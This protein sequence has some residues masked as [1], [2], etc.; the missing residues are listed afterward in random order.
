[1]SGKEVILGCQCTFSVN[2]MSRDGSPVRGKEGTSATEESFRSDKERVESGDQLTKLLEEVRR[3][4]EGQE[5]AVLK[6]ERG[7][8]RDPYLLKRRGNENQFR[9]CEEL[10]D[11]VTTASSSVARAERGGGKAAFDRAKEALREGMDLISRRQKLIKFADRSETGWAVVE[12]YVDDD[13]ADD[14]EDEKRMER[15]ERMAERKLA[16]KHK[17]T[18]E[19][20]RMK[21]RFPF[22]GSS[23][24]EEV[25]PPRPHSFC[26]PRGLRFNL[27]AGPESRRLVVHREG[28]SSVANS[29]ISSGTVPGKRS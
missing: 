25:P 20:G 22:G 13:L 15:A 16:K 26:L 11:R 4:R 27:L 8:R 10:A 14:S 9:F 1:M 3:L 5:D 6:L 7:A 29:V 18:Q 21:R 23:R 17:A 28:A 19:T 12:E 2:L 24:Q